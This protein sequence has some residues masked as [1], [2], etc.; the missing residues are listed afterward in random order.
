MAEDEKTLCLRRLLNDVETCT[1]CYEKYKEYPEEDMVRIRLWFNQAPWF[2]PPYG[3]E[4]CKEVKGFLGMGEFKTCDGESRRVIFLC[5][6]PS[7]GTFPSEA[8]KYFYKLLGE[9]GFENAHLTD[10][11]KCRGKTNEPK[12][13]FEN[14]AKKCFH[15]LEQ[16]IEIIKPDL[17]VAVDL[18][19]KRVFKFL[20]KNLLQKYE[21]KLESI[22]HYSTIN[23][24]KREERGKNKK[25][26]ETALERIKKRLNSL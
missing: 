3:S 8:D 21:G 25:K 12:K 7:T 5:K 14:M 24:S 10:L 2:F 18:E 15:F 22:P 16:E 1:K 20:K 6:R 26:L 19:D 9:K 23:R 4:E 13:V 17:I 11:I